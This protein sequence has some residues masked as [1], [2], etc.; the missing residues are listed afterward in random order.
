VTGGSVPPPPATAGG[1][2]PPT[3]TQTGTADS[4][5]QPAVAGGATTK[6]AALPIDLTNKR[7]KTL[8][9]VLLAYPLLILATAPFRAPARLPRGR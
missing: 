5:Q 8:A 3:T 7:L 4:G 2:V 1:S 6:A 9:L